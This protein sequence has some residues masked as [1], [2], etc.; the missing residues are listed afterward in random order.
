MHKLLRKV[1]CL[2]AFSDVHKHTPKAVSPY[3]K[4]LLLTG[5]DSIKDFLPSTTF[6]T[7]TSS[8]FPSYNSLS[9]KHRIRAETPFCPS[10]YHTAY[11]LQAL[12]LII[13]IPPPFAQVPQTK[14]SN[15][16]LHAQP[17]EGH[18]PPPHHFT[19]HQPCHGWL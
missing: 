7:P 17:T 11:L 18:S 19:S 5:Q 4:R 16:T 13:C 15:S 9:C 12:L 14:V 2:K 8:C 6:Y 3:Q 1:K 10:C